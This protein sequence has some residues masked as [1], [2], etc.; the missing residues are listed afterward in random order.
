M[1]NWGTVIR[2]VFTPVGIVL[3][4]AMTLVGAFILDPTLGHQL[5]NRLICAVSEI[6][7]AV[8]PLVLVVTGMWFMVKKVF[9]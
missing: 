3:V 6:V 8:L 2:W 9:K 4:G 5:I 7:F 1:N